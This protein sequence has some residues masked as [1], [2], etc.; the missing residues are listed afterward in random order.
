MEQKL[1]L[2]DRRVC[3][4]ELGGNEGEENLELLPR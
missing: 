1:N 4:V 2:R 3:W